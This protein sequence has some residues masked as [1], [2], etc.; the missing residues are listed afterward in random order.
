MDIGL[1]QEQRKQSYATLFRLLADVVVLQ[2]KTRQFHWNVKGMHFVPLHGFF[3]EQYD[4]FNEVIDD[5]AE[6]I[7]QLGFMA[8]FTLQELLKEARLKESEG[9]I[10]AHEMLKQLLEDHGQLVRQI[11]SDVE[12]LTLNGDAGNADFLTG[13]LQNHEK[14]VWMLQAMLAS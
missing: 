6:R 2:A 13:L 10:S 9:E 7:K 5:T 4:A 14:T 1:N 8:P 12:F 3:G 11:R